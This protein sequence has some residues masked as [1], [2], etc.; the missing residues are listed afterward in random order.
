M[1]NRNA[2]NKNKAVKDR[3]LKLILYVYNVTLTNQKR[4][5]RTNHMKGGWLD[6]ISD[7]ISQY[8]I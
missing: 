8:I 4:A 7:D 6:H 3:W 2:T 5:N 1:H